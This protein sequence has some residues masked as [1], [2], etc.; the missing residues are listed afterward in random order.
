MCRLSESD[1]S[2]A[3]AFELGH[4]SKGNEL[5]GQETPL[6]LSKGAHVSEDVH[7]SDIMSPY[8]AGECVL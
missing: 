3:A 5:H 2:R 8:T 1:F 7:H 6:G 4:H